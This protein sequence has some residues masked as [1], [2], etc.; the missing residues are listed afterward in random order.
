VTTSAPASIVRLSATT[1]YVNRLQ[2]TWTWI[3]EENRRRLP[4]SQ[5]ASWGIVYINYN[6]L[7]CTSSCIRVNRKNSDDRHVMNWCA[8]IAENVR[9]T[10]IG[11]T[12]IVDD[13]GRAHIE[14]RII[15]RA[16]SPITRVPTTRRIELGEFRRA[17]IEREI[18]AP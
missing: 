7:H 1:S 17:T 14:E 15:S 2:G 3:S 9:Q 8:I 10:Q 6:C 4:S 5:A 16:R 13:S 12:H 11:G 18:S